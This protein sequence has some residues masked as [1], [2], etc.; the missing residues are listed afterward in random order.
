MLNENDSPLGEFP[1]NDAM[2]T[3][4]SDEANNLVLEKIAPEQA[5]IINEGDH[6]K[7]INGAEGTRL[8]RK[9]LRS[10]AIRALT[11]GD[12]I[13]VGNYTIIRR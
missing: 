5:V 9:K 11:H 6:L 8:N 4:G 13:H 10:E 3:I 7:L 12:E 1:F 2:F